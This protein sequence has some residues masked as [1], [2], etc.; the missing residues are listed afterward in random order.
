MGNKSSE[1]RVFFASAY[2]PE[3]KGGSG[4]V[5]VGKRRNVSLTSGE[6]QTSSLHRLASLC[7]ETRTTVSTPPPKRVPPL[8]RPR[9]DAASI[10]PLR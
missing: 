10:V 7:R 3:I 2:A 4:G 6:A 8:P 9:V 5:H 1:G